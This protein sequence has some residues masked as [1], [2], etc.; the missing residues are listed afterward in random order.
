M[1]LELLVPTVIEEKLHQHKN[2]II[3]TQVK[4]QVSSVMRNSYSK[5]A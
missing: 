4:M 5:L 1:W 3:V 2:L